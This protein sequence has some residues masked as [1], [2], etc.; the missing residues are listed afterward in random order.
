[1]PAAP[2]LSLIPELEEVIQHGS[3]KKR[4]DTLE[5]ITT[6][7]L[8]GASRLG[9]DQV[10]LFDG[11]FCLLIDEIETKARAELSNRLAPVD[12][13][14]VKVLRTLA[15]DDDILV[16]GPILQLAPR[17][18]ES[19]LIDVARTKSQAHLQAI[20]SRKTLG[21]AVTD[22]L[23]RRGD[24]DVA[25]KVASNRGAKLSRHS[26][27]NLMQRAEDDG[28]LAEK[29][30]MRP[31]IP[32]PLFRDLLIKA[33]EVVRE[34]LLAS[35]P[36]DIKAEINRILQRVSKEVGTNVGPRDY[37]AAQRV[38]LNLERTKSLNENSVAVFCVEGKYEE[39]VVAL[40]M[41]AKAPIAVVDRLMTKGEPDAILILCKAIGLEWSTVKAV[42]SLQGG[43]DLSRPDAD[44]AFANFGRLSASTAR[45]V[46]RFW[47]VRLPAV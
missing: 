28:V 1:M 6:L 14:P 31:D 42:L 17:L 25:R 44:E 27:V 10:D 32:A 22:I 46:V 8:D 29:V 5:R 40:A 16:A 41:L 24:R 19:D 47:Q 7:F 18:P 35:A 43:R 20:S 3:R 34:R 26:F 13:A 11:V 23:V 4:A 21:E 39:T 37:R 36:P 45:R 15:N 33:T 12:N 30:G 2:A 38:V 9:G